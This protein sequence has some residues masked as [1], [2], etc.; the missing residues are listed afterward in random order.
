M[1]PKPRSFRALKVWSASSLAIAMLGGANYSH[2]QEADQAD[3]EKRQDTVVVTGFI[4]QNTSSTMKGDVAIRDVPLTI[5]SYGE[6]L[7]ESV[8]AS[9]LS[10]L[11]N[12]MAGVQQAGPSGYDI[13]IRGFQSGNEDPNSILVDG[14]PGLT[15]TRSSPP[16]I[17]VASI[18]VVKGPASVLYG[19]VQ[20]GGFVN[21]I[22]KKPQQ[23]AH[24]SI[25]LK[26]TGY[27]GDGTD[28]G[29]SLGYTVTADLT[30]AVNESGSMAYRLVAEYKDQ[31]SFYDGSF[32]ESTFLAPSFSVE[33]GDRTDLLVQ[34]EYINS[35]GNL[36][37]GLVAFDLDYR[38]I[39]ERPTRYSEPADEV[40]EEGYGGTITLDHE[41][42]N[43]IKWHTSIRSVFHGD[44]Y[45]GLR[46]RRFQDATTLRRQDRA[47]INVR[48][49]NFAD[50]NLSLKFDTGWIGHKLLVGA[51]GGRASTDFFRTRL[52]NGNATSD[53]DIYDPVYGQFVPGP[54]T[55]QNRSATEQDTFGVYVQ[56]QLEFTEQWKAV[57]AV[58]YEEFETTGRDLLNPTAPDELVSGNEVSPMF[59]VIYQPNDVWSIYTSYATSFNPPSPGAVDI[60][61]NIISEAEVGK[62][63]EGG[64]KVELF[65]G[66]VDAT[67][68][69]FTIDKENVTESLGNNVFAVIGAELSEGFELEIDA[70]LRDNWQVLFGYSYTDATISEDVDQ[71]NVGQQITNVP[72]NTASLF[73]RYDVENGPLAGLGMT[74]GV[75]YTGDRFGTLPDGLGPRL[76]LPG[77]TVADFGL[78]YDL[79]DTQLSLR[80]NNIFDE[81]YYQ[82]ASNQYR[83]QPGAPRSVVFSIRKDF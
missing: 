13:T 9:Q 62:Q 12:Y 82:S 43:F 70:F 76:E 4:Q 15:T 55:G 37:D 27:I 78:L 18:D 67:A 16:T 45:Q 73:S 72:L 10:D 71:L 14:M 44:D 53:I 56:D 38:N 51:N 50:T 24:Y 52:D 49:Y 23:D 39:A 2:A 17:N 20:P 81:E 61:G 29:D 63:I 33:L 54:V 7:I 40:N 65:D 60:N 1:Q 74:F 68:S 11:Y 77:Y 41:F 22:T 25:G 19:K 59:G 36:Y 32:S 30:G 21:I 31:P 47:Q 5:T 79:N 69:V 3:E 64:V 83:I 8:E 34:A 66:R 26:S 48:R 6:A 42:N 80:F 57:A 75:S 35:T 28:F 46:N 58:R